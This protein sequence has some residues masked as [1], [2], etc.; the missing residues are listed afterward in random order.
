VLQGSRQSSPDQG[1]ESTKTNRSIASMSSGKTASPR[2]SVALAQ[3]V[4][5]VLN[6]D[7]IPQENGQDLTFFKT[8]FEEHLTKTSKSKSLESSLEDILNKSYERTMKKQNEPDPLRTAV[9]FSALDHIIPISGRFCQVLVLVRR[10]MCEAV[11]G[12]FPLGHVSSPFDSI[13]FFCERASFTKNEKEFL[14]VNAQLKHDLELQKK[15]MSRCIDRLDSANA[16]FF[17]KI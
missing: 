1:V 5:E 13:P 11:Y 14:L 16:D 8:W 3:F 7:Q 17:G 6:G 4:D 15:Q 9:A 2:K 10:I 12:V